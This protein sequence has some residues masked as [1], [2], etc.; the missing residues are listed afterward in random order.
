MNFKEWFLETY[1]RDFKA[2]FPANDAEYEYEYLDWCKYDNIEPDWTGRYNK[3]DTLSELS[4]LRR[5]LN[6]ISNMIDD[7]EDA[8]DI[9]KVFYERFY[10]GV[11][12]AETCSHAMNLINQ[13]K[14]EGK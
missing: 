3:E 10:E 4:Q 6:Y 8:S 13:T 14:E 7:N 9:V 5:N 11:D 2:T 12:Y 1:G